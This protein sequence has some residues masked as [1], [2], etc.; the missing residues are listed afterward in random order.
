M[1]SPYSTAFP[2]P[3]QF[4]GERIVVFSFPVTWTFLSKDPVVQ[5]PRHAPSR[6]GSVFMATTAVLEEP[7][8]SSATP[9]V[10]YLEPGAAAIPA[11]RV[12]IPPQFADGMSQ[13]VRAGERPVFADR[14][15]MVIPKMNRPAARPSQKLVSDGLGSPATAGDPITAVQPQPQNAGGASGAAQ[16]ATD[17]AS[18]VNRI[19]SLA[20]QSWSRMSPAAII[21]AFSLALLLFAG[22]LLFAPAEKTPRRPAPVVLEAGPALAINP[23]SWVPLAEWPRR[24]S[25]VHGS[26][27]MTDFRLDFQGQI[28]SNALGFVFRAKDGKNFYGEKLG[29]VKSGP[30]TSA[31]VKHFTVIDGVDQPATELPLS[32]ALRPEIIYKIRIEAVG[33]RFT[34]WIADRKIDEWTDARIGSGGVGVFSDRGERSPVASGIAVFPLA[35]K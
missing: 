2:Q 4:G 14:W 10:P 3:P 6:T 24:I 31:L 8:E 19:A 35:R 13:R 5:R 29:I 9:L 15:E 23:S 20:R 26:L 1:H 12:E 18:R 11:E 7:A 17:F 34:T 33:N 21:A 28:N 27:T 32:I 30:E 22:G 25:V 16:E